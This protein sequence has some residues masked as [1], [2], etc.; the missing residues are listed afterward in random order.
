M[1]I[2]EMGAQLLSQKLGIQVDTST[3]QSA[4]SDLLGDGSG[5]IDLA[6]LAGK[7]ASNGELGSLVTSW[8]GDGANASI[9]P[10]SLLG[11]L[12]ES[13]VSQFASAIGTDTGTAAKG[14]SDVIPEMM[15][16]ASSGGSLLESA[17]GLGGLMG[18]A[19]SFLS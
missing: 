4:L 13:N 7:M 12:G 19:K 8:L 9:S 15:D 3:I 5:N 1:D 10:E 16:K 2:L 18:A 14:L 11:M 6:G 17:G